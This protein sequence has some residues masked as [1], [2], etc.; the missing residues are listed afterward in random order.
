VW[1]DWIAWERKFQAANLAELARYPFTPVKHLSSRGLGSVSR[2]FY[3]PKTNSM[4]GA[5]RYPGVLPYV[6][7]LS[8]DT[9]KTSKLANIKG[10]MLYSV[11]SLAYDPDRRA[12]FYTEDNYAYRTF[13]RSISTRANARYSCVMRGSATSSSTR[14]TSRSGEFATR[15]ASRRSSESRRHTPASIRSTRSTI[16]RRRSISIFRRTARNCRRR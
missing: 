10:S 12:A 3:D 5:F 6:G 8:L 14:R 11:T 13:F 1:S 4:I 2:T 9:G 7:L 15:T 16:T